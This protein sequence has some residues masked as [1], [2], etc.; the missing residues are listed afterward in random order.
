VTKFMA[1]IVVNSVTLKATAVREFAFNKPASESGSSSEE[2]LVAVFHIGIS[3]LTF[4][5]P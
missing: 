2:H 3:C 5:D 1:M 4:K